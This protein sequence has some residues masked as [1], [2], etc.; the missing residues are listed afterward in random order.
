MTIES[1]HKICSRLSAANRSL[2]SEFVLD[3][4]SEQAIHERTNSDMKKELAEV[5][6]KY[7]ELLSILEEIET[8]LKT[9]ELQSQEYKKEVERLI[10]KTK[11]LGTT[12]LQ[13]TT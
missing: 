8:K 4:K 3:L 5:N 12:I 13:P 7:S 1:L 6:E 2:L 9:S 11:L 10:K